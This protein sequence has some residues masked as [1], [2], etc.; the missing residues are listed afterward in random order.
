ME[1]ISKELNTN[2]IVLKKG[3]IDEFS[4]VYEYDYKHL[5]RSLV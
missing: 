2:N 3:N 4:L 5:N 1:H